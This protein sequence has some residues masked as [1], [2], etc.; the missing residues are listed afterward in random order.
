MLHRY[1]QVNDVHLS[2][3]PPSGRT[4]SYLDDVLAKLNWCVEYAIATGAAIVITGDLWHR[5][6]AA[7]TTHRT[8]QRVRA[9]L[10]IAAA[11]RPVY[12]VPGNHDEAHGGGLA[13]QPLL[14]V[15][16]DDRIRLL[17]G[18]SGI[19]PLIAGVPWSNAFERAGG[20]QAFATAVEGASSEASHAPLVFTHSPI[21]LRPYPFG[22]EAQGWLLAA[23]LVPLLPAHVRLVAHGH[24]HNGHKA[25]T[26]RVENDGEPTHYLTFS[27][28]G[29]LARG[30]LSTDDVT[31]RP[32]IA[33]ITYDDVTQAVEVRYV[34]VE[35][36][37]PAD[38]VLRIEQHARE[39][40]R[41]GSVEALAA[42]LAGAE[43]EVVDA[44]VMRAHLR[45]L[46]RPE[47]IAEDVWQRGLALADAALDGVGG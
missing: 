28:P 18:R 2:D 6:N 30:S 14:S 4:A 20:L 24:F 17:D 9:T 40:H 19:D 47:T 38:D 46:V 36:A 1:I 44:D 27:N 15:V 16:D 21:S 7:H 22:P 5:K 3:Q 8:V 11:H 43:A 13:G 25:E 26:W 33:D 37:R 31:R 42:S 10:G 34:E 23:D 41:D 29:A 12:I 39:A 45:S 32:A 35:C